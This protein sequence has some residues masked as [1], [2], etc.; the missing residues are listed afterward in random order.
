[1]SKPEWKKSK[2]SL[3]LNF[4]THPTVSHVSLKDVD[5][6][7]SLLDLKEQAVAQI[8]KLYESHKQAREENFYLYIA[9]DQIEP[10]SGAFEKVR[11]VYEGKRYIKPQLQTV[12]LSVNLHSYSIAN[13]S[14]YTFILQ[15]KCSSVSDGQL[16]AT[17]TD[18]T[19][20]KPLPRKTDLLY[21]YLK[22]KRVLQLKGISGVG[23]TVYLTQLMEYIRAHGTVNGNPP[24]IIFING[25]PKEENSVNLTSEGK[26]R[27]HGK[28]NYPDILDTGQATQIVQGRCANTL[29]P[30]PYH[31]VYGD[32]FIIHD[33][34]QCSYWDSDLWNIFYVHCTSQAADIYLIATSCWGSDPT[35]SDISLFS[36]E[37]SP[38]IAG[39]PSMLLNIEKQIGMSINDA[40]HGPH[41]DL[42]LLLTHDE[43]EK[44]IKEHVFQYQPIKD[45][46][47]LDCIFALS[48]G[49]IATIIA[50]FDFFRSQAHPTSRGR[51]LGNEHDHGGPR[52]MT[53]EEMPPYTLELMEK[54]MGVSLRGI[55]WQSKVIVL[56]PTMPCNGTRLFLEKM[57]TSLPKGLPPPSSDLR[58][59]VDGCILSQMALFLQKLSE[60]I[61]IPLNQKHLNAS[62]R[63]CIMNGWVTLRT[64]SYP[65]LP[66]MTISTQ[67]ALWMG[68]LNKVLLLL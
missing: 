14:T 63:Q 27:T 49:H 15:D 5:P 53:C 37:V 23:K 39:S 47:L 22:E 1:M 12:S 52:V 66:H 20:L 55:H 10:G 36:P 59:P 31:H 24:V 62:I 51:F 7:T 19:L 44:F 64:E 6:E 17:P 16:Q 3:T 46:R 42:Q 40:F 65:S 35:V 57:R 25:W 13:Q 4:W 41:Q 60:E 21:E 68:S 61:E 8:K 28:V 2:L 67:N 58:I 30:N 43:Y 18:S 54:V 56:Q 34:A 38:R 33:E 32:I 48:S 9:T 11:Q 26:L 45:Q 50:F 29:Q